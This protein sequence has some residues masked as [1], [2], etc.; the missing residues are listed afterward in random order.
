MSKDNKGATGTSDT[1]AKTSADE[2][3]NSADGTA[4][5]TQKQPKRSLFQELRRRHVIAV[6]TVYFVGVWGLVQV[7]DIV[8]EAFAAPEWVMQ[9]LIVLGVLG[10]PVAL[11]VSYVFDLTPQGFVV[12]DEQDAL[13]ARET[14]QDAQQESK[15][16]DE[17]ILDER[18]HI[19]VMYA[20]L[21]YLDI[22]PDP[23][24]MRT[25]DQIVENTT[26]SVVKRYAGYVQRKDQDGL[27]V[28]FGYPDATEQDARHAVQAG[29]A[30]QNG[31]R[32]VR[33][34]ELPE[35]EN[36][37]IRVGI[38]SGI[39]VV[40]SQV[41]HA[42]PQILER[43][44]RRARRVSESARTSGQVLISSATLENV[45]GYFTVE[46]QL[47]MSL[48][49]DQ[50]TQTI[51]QV[52]HE[53]GARNRIE[54][55][56]SLVTL[57]GRD[58][59]FELMKSRWQQTQN[60]QGSVILLNG[61][62]GM[63]KSRLVHELK[64]H[65]AQDPRAWISECYCSSDFQNRPL[66]AIGDLFDANLFAEIDDEQAKITRLEGYFAQFGIDLEATVPLFAELLGL[67]LP[68]ERYSPP[69]L[70]PKRKK[71]VIIES[72]IEALL[73]RS[74]TQPL[75]LVIEDLHWADASFFD[76]VSQLV[77]FGPNQ[78]ILLVCTVRPQ[79]TV[80]WATK[81]HV[82]HINLSAIDQENI[83]SLIR[84]IAKDASL[85]SQ[86]IRQICDLA[87]GNPLYAEELTLGA[88]RAGEHTHKESGLVPKTLQES[89]L[90]RLDVLK[91]EVKTVA[92]LGA[93]IGARFDYELIAAF[94]AHLDIHALDE[95]LD[96]LVNADVVYQRGTPP[97]SQ[98]TFKHVL[99]QEAA[100]ETLLRRERENY[101]A[102]IAEILSSQFPELASRKPEVLAHHLANGGQPEQA[103]PHY[104]S[105]G[106]MA[107]QQSAPVE[108]A[109]YFE[110]AL[111]LLNKQEPAD[112]RNAL[113]LEIQIALG[114]ALMA[115]KGYTSSS[116][117]AAY[118]KAIELC[119]TST[120]SARMAPPIFGLWTHRVVAGDLT[121]A[122]SLGEKLQEIAITSG[123][124]DLLLESH[125]LSGVT[126][127]YTGPMAE[128][129]RHMESAAQIYDQ[130]RH[131]THALTFGQDPLMAAISYS[132]IA[133]WWLGEPA[134]AGD[135]ADRAIRIARDLGHTRSLAF[136]LAN[137]AR[138]H[139]KRGAYE[140]C[141]EVGEEGSYLSAVFGAP[142]FK[143]MAEFHM[144]AARY[145]IEPSL[146]HLEAMTKA[147]QELKTVGNS[148]SMPYYFSVVAAAQIE[149]DMLN[150]AE[151]SL[152]ISHEALSRH[153]IDS[154][155]A[156][157]HR[158]DALLSHAKGQK[159]SAR[160]SIQR[161]LSIAEQDG[162]VYWQ[163]ASHHSQFTMGMAESDSELRRAREALVDGDA[164]PLLTAVDQL[165]TEQA[166]A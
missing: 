35:Q 109:H 20:D 31:L 6:G 39:A 18:R 89:L 5:S 161:S 142:D 157:V 46:P 45:R 101:H 37:D 28:Y 14:S 143:A 116:V 148:L 83:Q 65:V 94:A 86:A 4:Q 108:A 112:D 126:R 130:E 95:E 151:E 127:S 49:G 63:G 135:S 23:E 165:L 66:H 145:E 93:T 138:C 74:D 11:V 3:P 133:Q 134:K 58:H 16:P 155:A 159:D 106:R 24:T 57:N 102:Q 92:K 33:E 8:L 91:G 69:Q 107:A 163:L 68:D 120:P 84:D 73:A 1:S 77:A 43:I 166:T 100:Y 124:E 78:P 2:L 53:S 141:I 41:E 153:G 164:L 25:L 160:Q 99:L 87:Q 115:I 110:E 47:E 30:I 123:S 17:L 162:A 149:Q 122:V 12:T 132:A 158:I 121:E 52:T 75:M 114:P 81:S 26:S 125:V 111:K 71:E 38:D 129:L 7:A 62:A 9:L 82:T 42:T 56:E 104:Y 59:E 79:Q 88:L 70:S 146:A 10:F 61:E 117:R 44:T 32:R 103:I 36:L 29:L 150:R 96:A 90:A 64:R 85:E 80:D 154:D 131:G 34:R 105:A 72:F 119:E 147:L 40:E 140:R 97:K 76:L 118:E 54:A 152:S 13:A 19:T 67:P 22:D 128:S 50:E 98:Y 113:E 136:A 156:E 139:L 15:H 51:V 137:G 21:S 55:R 48:P 27:V 60:G 144:W